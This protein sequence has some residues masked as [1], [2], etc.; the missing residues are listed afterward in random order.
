M[1][2][3]EERDNFDSS[4]PLEAAEHGL[5][6]IRMIDQGDREGACRLL[7]K[8]S[9]KARGR[10]MQVL[11]KIGGL[12]EADDLLYCAV[13]RAVERAETYDPSKGGL[14]YWL[15]R[16]ADNILRDRLRE[17]RRRRALEGSVI[18]GLDSI[19]DYHSDSLYLELVEILRRLPDPSRTILLTDLDYG[20][21]A[22]ASVLARRLGKAEQTVLNLRWEARKL[23]KPYLQQ[24]FE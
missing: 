20:G 22:P 19:C 23:A 17:L 12:G 10:L 14:S 13:W 4:A 7:L 21:L 8:L 1:T 3:P 11:G 15:W 24:L 16:I 6:F 18:P 5:N 9:G 2:L